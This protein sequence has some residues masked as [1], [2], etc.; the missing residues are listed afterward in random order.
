MTAV[1]AVVGGPG[2]GKS[3]LCAALAERFRGEGL[4]VDHFREEEILSRADF[5][6]V[7]SQFAGGAGSVAP[8]TLVEDYRGYVSRAVTDGVDLLI[9]DALVP[10]IPSLIAWGHS[11]AELA[12]VIG[13]LEDVAA[14]VTVVVVML[15]ADPAIT[16]QRAISR[17]GEGWAESYIR[18]LSRLPGTSH[19]VSIPTAVDQLRRD[20][21]I[22]RRLLARSKWRLV[23][24][25]ATAEARSMADSV[26]RRL[27][28]I[29]AG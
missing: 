9:T 11:E 24:V 20:A 22:T 28:A 1:V 7:A 5:A 4:V 8:R 19:V 16:L 2:S 17:E 29:L 6:Q 26:V 25:D 14:G 12:R 23:E 18:K 21:D 27:T 3:T 13:D 15:T 10:F